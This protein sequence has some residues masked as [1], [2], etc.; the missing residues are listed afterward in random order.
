MTTAARYR[1]RADE[2]ES[3]ARRAST[4]AVQAEWEGMAAAY[5]KLAQMVEGRGRAAPPQAEHEAKESA[6]ETGGSR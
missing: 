2:L 5:R 3:L 1:A 4:P 6:D